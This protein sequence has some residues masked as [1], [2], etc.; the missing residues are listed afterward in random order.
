MG[1]GGGE[2]EATVS[3]DYLFILYNYC[4]LLCTF[5]VEAGG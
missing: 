5:V 3:L 4:N 2:G 1:V